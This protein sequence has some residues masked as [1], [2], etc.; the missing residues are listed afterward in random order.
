MDR[1]RLQYLHN[2]SAYHKVIELDGQVAGFLLA[3]R[4]GAEYDSNNYNWF[5]RRYQKFLYVDRIVIAEQA[6][7]RGLGQHFYQDLISVARQQSIP[8]ISCEYYTRPANPVSARFHQ[9]W[10]FEQVASVSLPGDK[11][12]SMQVLKL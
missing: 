7:G 2:L 10:G 11:E 9:A 1:V 5:N 6:H 12:V 3:F 4:E 8:M